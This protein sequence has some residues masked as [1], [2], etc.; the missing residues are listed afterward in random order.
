MLN[1]YTNDQSISINSDVKHCIY[2]DD[3]ATVEQHEKFEIVEEK[4]AATLDVLGKYYRRNHLKSNPG[5]AQVCAFH[6]RN[7]CSNRTL[8]VY[9]DEMKPTNTQRPK[10]LGVT[11][12][13]IKK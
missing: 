2:V 3:T 10:Y 1:I 6:L 11:L 7:R 12:D 5:K 4:L 9:W 8:N 13:V